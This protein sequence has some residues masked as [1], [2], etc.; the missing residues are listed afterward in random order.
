M[1]LGGIIN[2]VLQQ[3]RWFKEYVLHFTNA[4]TIINNRYVDA[5]EGDG[6]FSGFNPETRAYN[7]DKANWNYAG[8]PTPSAADVPP[9]AKAQAW[10]WRPRPMEGTL[11][12][13]WPKGPAKSAFICAPVPSTSKSR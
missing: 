11:S 12:A 5:E 8:E 1:F 9:E 2:Q 13:S 7:L 10:S 6:I 3:E 4:A